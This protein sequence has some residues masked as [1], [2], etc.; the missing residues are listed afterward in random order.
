M[1][2]Y[3]STPS[4]DSENI[5]VVWPDAVFATEFLDYVILLTGIIG[6]AKGNIFL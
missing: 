4:E 2:V 1:S 5:T 3:E 6:M